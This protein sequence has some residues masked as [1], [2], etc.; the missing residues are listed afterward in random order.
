MGTLIQGSQS[1]EQILGDVTVSADTRLRFDFSAD[2]GSEIHAIMFTTGEVNSPASSI[3]IL[4]SQTWGV[5]AHNDYVPG[6]GLQSYDI[7]V[8]DFF[9]GDFDRFVFVNDDDAGLGADSTWANVEIL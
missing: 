1:W 8:G 4:G 7:P 5:Q 6:S 2:V 9:T 3:Q